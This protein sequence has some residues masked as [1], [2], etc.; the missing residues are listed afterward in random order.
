MTDIF[1]QM[2][3]CQLLWNKDLTRFL[4]IL[5]STKLRVKK[6]FL[7]LSFLN[8]LLWVLVLNR[9][10]LIMREIKAPVFHLCFHPAL[11]SKLIL[12]YI[13][14]I[15]FNTWLDK[16]FHMLIFS[17]SSEIADCKIKM[18][19]IFNLSPYAGKI[20]VNLLC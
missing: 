8:V 18:W 17:S 5:Q 14:F 12:I 3:F 4:D 15:A 16:H 1:F 9:C 20:T 6:L 19:Q 2:P 10:L 7:I 11:Y 13:F